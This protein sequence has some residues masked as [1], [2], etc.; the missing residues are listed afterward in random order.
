MQERPETVIQNTG[1]VPVLDFR[2]GRRQTDTSSSALHSDRRT[3]ADGDPPAGKPVPGA[4]PRS[5]DR[6][7]FNT[8]SRQGLPT[9][10][11]K[12]GGAG[13]GDV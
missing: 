7:S 13:G 4:P 8:S 6:N 10:S 1:R 12:G 5:Q 9:L 11:T 2:P 3:D